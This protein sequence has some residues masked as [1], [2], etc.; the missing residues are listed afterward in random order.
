[1]IIVKLKGGLGNQLFQYALGRSIALAHHKQVK[2]DLSWFDRF[3][4][5]KYKLGHFNTEVDIATKI[6]TIALRKW[7]RKDGKRYLPLNFFRKKEALHIEESDYRFQHKILKVLDNT[8]LDGNWQSEKY[9]KNIENIIREEIIL[10][11][12]VN[13]N[14]KQ[15]TQRI[16]ENNSVS[17]HI[18]R[19]DYTT[20][21]VQRVLKLCSPK[22]YHQAIEFIKHKTK[23][24]TFFVFS[25]DIEWVKDNIETNTPTIFVSNG[26]LE[27]YEELMLMSKCKHNI[28]ANSSFSWW[29]A[30]LN[31]NPDKIVITPKEWFN[32]KNKNINDLIPSHWIKI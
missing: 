12:V 20:V 32:D 23:K 21:K 22:Y 9:F 7:K 13:E 6:E 8:Y 1:M 24:P 29:G 19:G 27:D 15:L 11:E 17:L 28:I 18:R 5:R 31:N 2:F 10:K 26:N 4:Q 3:P 25:D 16:Q 30:W 14:L